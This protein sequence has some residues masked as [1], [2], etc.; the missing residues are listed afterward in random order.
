[1]AK[2]GTTDIEHLAAAVGGG[3]KES[4]KRGQGFQSNQHASGLFWKLFRKLLLDFSFSR[5]VEL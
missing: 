2:D 1:M 5:G 4:D 3:W